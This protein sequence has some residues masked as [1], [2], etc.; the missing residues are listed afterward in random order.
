MIVDGM[1]HTAL[2]GLLLVELSKGSLRFF[3]KYTASASA[4]LKVSCCMVL[5]VNVATGEELP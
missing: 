3:A 1:I 4:F 5:G 2:S